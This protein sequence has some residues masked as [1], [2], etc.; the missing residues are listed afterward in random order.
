M[1][2][3]SLASAAAA[4]DDD[5]SDAACSHRRQHR[6]T[7]EDRITA[8]SSLKQTYSTPQLLCRENTT[9]KRHLYVEF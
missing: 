4:D 7:D 8:K 3:V 9:G 2:D 5:E 6:R 1:E